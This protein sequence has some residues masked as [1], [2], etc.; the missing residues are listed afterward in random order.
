[1]WFLAFCPC[2]LLALGLKISPNNSMVLP[3][4]MISVSAFW[5]VHLSPW[6]WPE[7]WAILPLPSYDFTP[8]LLP[9]YTPPFFLRSY[10]PV[11]LEG[12]RWMRGYGPIS[13]E[14]TLFSVMKPCMVCRVAIVADFLCLR[15]QRLQSIVLR[16]LA[17]CNKNCCRQPPL[18]LL[19][20]RNSG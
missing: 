2:F 8:A 4:S 10:F 1:M 12:E 13:V 9:V 3:T 6:Q 15:W 18:Q 20:E 14:N 17:L 5:F 7:P 16:K 11:A 19:S